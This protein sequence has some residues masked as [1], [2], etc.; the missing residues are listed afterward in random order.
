M[1]YFI[2]GVALLAGLLLAGRWFAEA[3]PKTLAKAFKWLLFG[4]IGAV[5]LYFVVSGRLLL[6]LA[7]LPA[8]L[9]WVLRFRSMARTAR[10]F[11]RMAAAGGGGGA[12]RGQASQVETR[13]LR[14]SL[15]HDSG[16]MDGEV[17]EGAFSGRRLSQLTLAELVALLQ[18]CA[19]ADPPSVQVL[20]AYMDRVHADWR[21]QAAGA[22]AGP[23]PGAQGTMSRDEA[24]QILGLEA[25]A[26]AEEI[27]AAYHR[28]MAGLHPDHGGSTYLASKLN[29]AKD[30]LLGG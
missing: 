5:F 29:Q 21:T 20:E 26:G 8:L 1:S 30:L 27:K 15:D 17:I 9:P 7:A 28:L 14:M 13:F 22:S 23:G 12:G 6:A 16:A 25:G 2:L 19:Q 18:T 11:S 24:F 3:D 4:L 10:N